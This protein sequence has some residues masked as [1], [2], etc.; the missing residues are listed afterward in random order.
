MTVEVTVPQIGEAVAELH[1]AAWLKKEG[2]YVKRGEP[3][4]EVDSDKAVVEVESFVEGTL[5]RILAPAGSAVMPL[6]V[7]AIIA[8]AGEEAPAEGGPPPTAAEAPAKPQKAGASPVARRV[9]AE[10][11]VALWAVNGSGPHGRVMS[12][13]VRRHAS[14]QDTPT[15]AA[16]PAREGRALASPR[17]RVRAR[18]LGLDLSRL[19]AGTGVDGMITVKD[20]EAAAAQTVTPA[21]QQ[22]APRR[23]EAQPLSRTRQAIAARMHLSKQSVPHFYLMADVDMSAAQALR[24][25][26]RDRLGWERAPTYTDLIVRACA[27]ALAAMPQVN[28]SYV[29][30]GV[31]RHDTVNIGVAVG[32]EDGL[33]VPVVREADRLSLAETSRRVRQLSE[34]ARSGRLQAA[35]LGQKSMVV[36]NLGMYGVDAFIAIIDLPDPMILAV[37]RVADRVVPVG[38]QIAIRPLCTLTLSVDHR[39]LDGVLG[40]R[41]LEGVKDHLENPYALLGQG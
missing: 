6:D 29:E 22:A 24:A 18:E 13:D 34:R 26:C 10:L 16:T 11:G 3:L 5:V 38:G 12:E 35:D 4:F 36:S 30:G 32:L 21:T 23:G 17:A 19:G 20:V 8:E 2:D 25:Y 14:G 41:F 31:A 15:A 37:G 39:V 40:A 27:L 9:A 28:I 7:V 1:V 33:I